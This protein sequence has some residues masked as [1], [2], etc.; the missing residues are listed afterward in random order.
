MATIYLIWRAG[1]EYEDAWAN[2]VAARYDR[3]AAQSLADKA[4]ARDQYLRDVEARLAAHME[5]FVHPTSLMPY[6]QQVPR[7]KWPS[8]MRQSEITQ[9][10]RDERAAIDEDNRARMVP[11]AD[12]QTQRY[13]EYR[14]AQVAYLADVEMWTREDA[15]AR[16]SKCNFAPYEDVRNYITEVEIE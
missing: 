15:E 5:S 10:M 3:V 12:N 4:A 6:P 2:V 13:V 14:E 11:Y 7:K 8:G 9:A 1:G 16:L